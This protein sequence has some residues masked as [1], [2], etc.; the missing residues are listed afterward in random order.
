MTAALRHRCRNPRCRSKLKTPV[1]N[2][3]RAFCCC[4]CFEAFYRIRCRVCERDITADPMTGSRRQDIGRRKFCGRKCK[5]KA[6]RFPH[7]YAW[8]LPHP[9]PRTIDSRNAH[10]TGLKSALRGEQRAPISGPKR[11][12]DIEVWGDRPWRDAVSSGGVAIQVSR[13]RQRALVPGPVP[14][15]L[16]RRP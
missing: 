9:I 2:N 12:L 7:D 11:V 4:G 8:E 16:R 14:E 15:F 3:H 6:A 5:A 1:E 13:L 10:S